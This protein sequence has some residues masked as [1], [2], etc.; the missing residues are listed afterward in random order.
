L[1]WNSG[2][3]YKEMIENEYLSELLAAV[4]RNENILSRTTNGIYDRSSSMSKPDMIIRAGELSC[5]AVG[6]LK[7]A[8]RDLFRARKVSFASGA[9]TRRYF[10]GLLEITQG[11]IFEI[12][13]VTF[14]TWNTSYTKC[15]FSELPI[16]MVRFYDEYRERVQGSGNEIENFSWAT[17]T[18]DTDLHPYGDGCGRLS[19]LHGSFFLVRAGYR[20]PM[21]K[22]RESYYH[23]MSV[24]EAEFLKYVRECFDLDCS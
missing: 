16:S 18:F 15:D 19:R 17:R 1:N 24:S 14:R 12:K 3:E 8:Y 11:G 7:E 23:A 20:L 21:F 4:E 22:S 10:D 9:A 6:N 5:R 13:S 2:K